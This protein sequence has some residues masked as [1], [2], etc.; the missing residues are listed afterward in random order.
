[1]VL[2]TW[3]SK[4][5]KIFLHNY[6]ILGFVSLPIVYLVTLRVNYN[7]YCNNLMEIFPRF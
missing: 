7:V 3:V 6:E 2:K 5:L 1:M 4:T